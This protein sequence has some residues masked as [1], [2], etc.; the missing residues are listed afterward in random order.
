MI[1]DPIIR[2]YAVAV[3]SF[4]VIA[5]INNRAHGLVL[6]FASII[7]PITLPTV[8]V[9]WIVRQVRVRG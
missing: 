7:W 4:F 6:L 2:Y 1:I 5:A 9:V 3:I 8:I